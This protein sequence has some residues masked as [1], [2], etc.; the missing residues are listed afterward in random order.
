MNLRLPVLIHVSYK[1]YHKHFFN[2]FLLICLYGILGNI[3]L[4][5]TSSFL[6]KICLSA[7][8]NQ[9][10]APVQIAM[11]SCVACMVD[12]MTIFQL[13]LKNKNFYLFLGIYIFG[14][15]IAWDLF[16]PSSLAD[17]LSQARPKILSTKSIF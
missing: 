5:S 13:K 6:H 9:E 1:L 11:F 14:N 15:G 12:P 17:S 7:A 10:W 3:L 2:Q 16:R 4:I 8:F